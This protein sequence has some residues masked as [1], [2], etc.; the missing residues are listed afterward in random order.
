MKEYFLSSN[1][2][3]LVVGTAVDFEHLTRPPLPETGYKDV[4]DPVEAENW[5]EAKDRLL[6]AYRWGREN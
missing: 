3:R 6:S 4:I 2:V 5:Q 1:G